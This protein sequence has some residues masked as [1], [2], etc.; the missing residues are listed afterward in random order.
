MDATAPQPAA[1]A[2][3]PRT[4]V[5]VF[6]C[7]ALGLIGSAA[8]AVFIHARLAAVPASPAIAWT[9]F[10]GGLLL[11]ALACVHLHAR[12]KRLQ[13]V[14]REMAAGTRALLEANRNLRRHAEAREASMAALRR[15]EARY[16][17]LADH[18]NDV[19]S[20][21]APGGAITYVSPSVRTL[22]GYD[23]DSLIGR[24]SY[25]LFPAR[26]VAATRRHLRT[27]MNGDQP[28]TRTYR[29]THR[30]GH[31]IWI[32]T[33]HRVLPES[34]GG[35]LLCISRD[36][37]ARR[38]AEA[39]LRDSE[40]M[41]RTVFEHS[42]VGMGL[43][44]TADGRF[45]RVNHAL[46]EL[47]GYSVAEFEELS[48]GDVTHPADQAVTPSE[49]QQVLAGDKE[50]FIVEKRYLHKNGSTVWI[51]GNTTLIRHADGEPRYFVTQIQDISDRKRVQQRLARLTHQQDLILNAAG[52]GICGVDRDGI[53]TFANRAAGETLGYLPAD[54]V[55]RPIHALEDSGPA[56]PR[57]RDC[58]IY[59]SI[60]DRETHYVDD[61]TF[62]HRSGRVLHVQYVSSPIIEQQRATGAVVVFSATAEERR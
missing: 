14:E 39:A 21:H 62:R 35:E 49:M 22:L 53:I 33:V 8:G 29:V 26:D 52:E 19:I 51:L 25:D 30:N 24:S 42:A 15:S 46:A 60:R 36:I 57:W 56:T 43:F 47:L 11:T 13:R 34:E 2:Q 58:R 55:R 5:S 9:L 37:T 40:A 16:R 59:Q 10:L 18:A 23:P 1:A 31:D 20:R 3:R 4:D 50:S 27:L 44:S 54:L 12:H 41:F 48:V 32:E 7:L 38:N 45:L 61:E 6:A 17:L 28:F